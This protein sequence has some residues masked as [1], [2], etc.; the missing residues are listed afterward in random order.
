[1][2][3]VREVQITCPDEETAGRIGRAA[4]EK[5]LAACANIMGPVRSIYRW[6]GAVEEDTEWTLL[7]KTAAGQIDALIAL[8]R[9]LHP[10]E[11]PAIL[12]H[13]SETDPETER[14]V[15]QEVGTGS[16]RPH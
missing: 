15:T 10:Y 6:K 13:E 7:L 1:M 2:S 9:E 5:R 11:L 12:V 16:G 8:V 3:I 4:V 14:W